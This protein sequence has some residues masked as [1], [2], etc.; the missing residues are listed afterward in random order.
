M[1]VNNNQISVVNYNIEPKYV[2]LLEIFYKI[3]KNDKNKILL[4]NNL[5]INF[6]ELISSKKMSYN[7]IFLIMNYLE[8]SIELYKNKKA[9]NNYQIFLAMNDLCNYF[10]KYFAVG[11]NVFIF[12]CFDIKSKHMFVFDLTKEAS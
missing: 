6:E 4:K 7:N 3:L 10:S 12:Y 8:E 1:R 11:R 2:K 9:K 5:I